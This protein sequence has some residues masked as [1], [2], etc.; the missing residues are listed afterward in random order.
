LISHP[1]SERFY[2]GKTNNLSVRKNKHFEDSRRKNKTFIHQWLQKYPDAIFEILEENIDETTAML[3]ERMYIS[4]FKS[5]SIPLMN[6]TNG[7]D[8]SSG[9]KHTEETK[10]LISKIHKGQ[11]YSEESL[12]I[13][14]DRKKGNNHFRF[15]KHFS[16]EHKLNASISHTKIKEE[17][18]VYDIKGNFV[19]RYNS[20]SE[21]RREVIPLYKGSTGDVLAN[22]RRKQISCNGYIFQF[23][24][25]DCIDTILEQMKF[26]P[27]HKKQLVRQYTLE[28]EFIEEFEN[29]YQAEKILKLRGI[30]VRSGDI[31]SCC[32]GHQK[33][34]RGSIWK[35]AN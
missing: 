25:D 27:I 8:G 15:G 20:P 9:Y 1:L 5:W 12:K 3:Y 31:R 2:V 26:S 11:I 29:S 4:L 35:Y 6:M 17:V 30:N 24:S 18:N 10:E 28:D 23:A 32:K 13:M 34:Y 33:M 19:G 7:G 16:E 14:S 22:C 21:A